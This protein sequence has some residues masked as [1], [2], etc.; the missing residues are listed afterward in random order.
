MIEIERL[1]RSLKYDLLKN[2]NKATDAQ[3][4]NLYDNR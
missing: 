1:M 2:V 4:K 3:I